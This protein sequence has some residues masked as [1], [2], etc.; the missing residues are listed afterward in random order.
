MTGQALTIES[1]LKEN[2]V[3]KP[4]QEFVNQSNVKKWMD[5]HD[6]KD[7]ERLF[8]KAKDIEWFWRSIEELCKLVQAI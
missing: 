4:T 1:L 6:I 3:F 5:S 7:L 2:R 8:E